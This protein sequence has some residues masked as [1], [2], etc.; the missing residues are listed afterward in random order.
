MEAVGVLVPDSEAD[1]DAES[2][3]VGEDEGL[4]P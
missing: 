2:D 4:E 1:V 3:T